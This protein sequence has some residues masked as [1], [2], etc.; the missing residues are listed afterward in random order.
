L[1]LIA[2]LYSDGILGEI[3]AKEEKSSGLN[4]TKSR[5]RK[6]QLLDGTAMHS[7]EDHLADI[8]IA[9]TDIEQP[10][11]KFKNSATCSTQTTTE[12]CELLDEDTAKE[13]KLAFV[14]A[15]NS[16]A[17][18]GL[19]P[20]VTVFRDE[21][22][23]SS[24]SAPPTSIFRVELP[25]YHISVA[26]KALLNQ[27]SLQELTA[28]THFNRRVEEY[29]FLKASHPTNV[30]NLSRSLDVTNAE[31]FLRFSKPSTEISFSVTS[32]D[33]YNLVLINFNGIKAGSG[34][35]ASAKRARKAAW[36]VAAV[37][38]ANESPK[39]LDEYFKSLEV[40][41][42]PPPPLDIN[43]RPSSLVLIQDTLAAAEAAGITNW[44]GELE[45]EDELPEGRGWRNRERLSS[46]AAKARSVH[47][48]AM[49][50][51]YQERD[52]LKGFRNAR[53]NLPMSQHSR[54]VLDIVSNNIY[55]IIVGS[56]GSGKTTQVPQIIM[57][58]YME[59]G[60]G[61]NCNII[62]TQ[63]RR[64]A[65]VSIAERVAEERGQ[66]LQDQIGYHIRFDDKAPQLGGNITY[67][68]TGVLLR[69]LQHSP[70]FVFD[71]IS[72]L[73]IDEVHERDRVID[74]L[75]TVLKKTMYERLK[76]R[77]KV[78]RVVLMSATMNSD[79]FSSYLEI[80]DPEIGTVK[81]PTLEVPGRNYRV[82]EQ[83]LDEILK[84]LS[85]IHGKSWTRSVCHEPTTKE[86]LEAER[87]IFKTEFPEAQFEDEPVFRWS[88]D[89]VNIDWK[90]DNLEFD[91]SKSE[92]VPLA[93]VTATV[94][95]IAATS[96][97][98]A[99]LVF[100][101]GLD[102]LLRIRSM[103]EGQ[104]DLGIDFQDRSKY[105]FFLLHSSLSE[106]QTDVF[107][108]LPQGCRKIILSTNIAETSVTIPDVQYVVDSGKR[109]EYSY[110][111]L[112][113]VS[114]LKCTWI[115]KSNSKQRAGRSGRVRNGHYY[116]LFTKERHESLSPVGIPELLRVDL[117]ETCLSIKAQ[118]FQEP[119]RDFLSDTIE[120]P[121]AAAVDAA[122]T[123]LIGLEALTKSEE[124]TPLGRLLHNLPVHPSLGKMILLGII[125]K[126]LDPMIILGASSSDRR[127][128][129]LPLGSKKDANTAKKELAGESRSDHISTINAFNRLREIQRS[130]GGDAMMAFARQSY[131]H[132]GAFASTAATAQQIEGVLEGAGLIPRNIEN[133]DIQ[134]GVASLNQN[135]SKEELL[136][137]LLVAGLRPRV[138][139]RKNENFYRTPSHPGVLVHPSSV[140]QTVS[141]PKAERQL[142]A[143]R[144]RLLVYSTVSL[145]G[146]DNTYFM[147]ETTEVTPLMLALFGGALL[148]SADAHTDVLTIDDWI[149][150][151]VSKGTAAHPAVRQ[152]LD[153][154]QALRALEQ[155][156]F[157][158][159]GK[160]AFLEGSATMDI[161]SSALVRLLETDSL[162]RE[163]GGVERELEITGVGVRMQES[164]QLGKLFEDWGRQSGI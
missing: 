97:A 9:S 145:T 122:I 94:T 78:P 29:H 22:Q 119:I 37:H 12:Y 143:L 151:H 73:I 52:D 133:R 55:S 48:L 4:E 162:D 76:S 105:R 120:P 89:E 70:D 47:L 10:D 35:S 58:H 92:Q 20:T 144:E 27:Y 152:V 85:N 61:A 112:T 75:L 118:A 28:F 128:F 25:E 3:W 24:R 132:L 116:A 141:L 11:Q 117:Q 149:P 93:L 31:G 150:L 42:E 110:D 102:T 108:S 57:D 72:H 146:D 6:S 126:C 1:H 104:S 50:Q 87:K 59:L 136:K 148:H 155:E 163:V 65:A 81:C 17:K 131:L 160:R 15:Y 60:D 153:L 86:Y 39:L 91:E 127:L 79:L 19:T 83:Y 109:R 135:S 54:Q 159:L 41:S 158:R 142:W 129:N 69:Q 21:S 80:N 16:C 84:S 62:C 123:E 101:P 49:H 2:Q 43:F 64:I 53:A 154:R 46:W 8:P 7:P 14:K 44:C 88:G 124:L 98:G 33:V 34:L 38:V 103:L 63:P 156:A 68:T 32:E 95:H 99:I 137:A 96:D 40:A 66:Q 106:D 134:Y 51:K 74:F 147:R 71:N 30:Q 90:K 125:Y 121:A 26:V 111:Q 164:G 77:K 139:V 100:L 140:N 130:S 13:Q 45:P 115:S 18:Y 161:F 157:G 5:T 67:C 113:Q 138:A 82:K 56:T 23:P 114:A 107:H 36:L